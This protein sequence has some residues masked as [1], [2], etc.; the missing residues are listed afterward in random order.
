MR[1]KRMVDG[2]TSFF[3]GGGSHEDQTSLELPVL[4]CMP[5]LYWNTRLVGLLLACGSQ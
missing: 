4:L 1:G 2:L 5:P 3:L